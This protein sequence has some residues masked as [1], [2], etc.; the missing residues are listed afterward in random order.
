MILLFS[1]L[2]SDTISYDCSVYE[3]ALDHL[4]RQIKH[5][6]EIID[7]EDVILGRRL[8]DDVV[9]PCYTLVMEKLDII[10]D[11]LDNI[12]NTTLDKKENANNKKPNE[13]WYRKM[14][15]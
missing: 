15:R 6:N 3:N 13:M 12:E 14:A 1:P 10:V 4:T 7:K 11:T 5:E 2:Y 9:N 8:L